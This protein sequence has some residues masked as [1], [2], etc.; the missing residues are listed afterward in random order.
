MSTGEDLKV[1]MPPP[2]PAPIP[3]SSSSADTSVGGGAA[4][5]SQPGAVPRRIEDASG[6]LL[7]MQPSSLTSR[8]TDMAFIEKVLGPDR[9]RNMR[10]KG[11]SIYWEWRAGTCGRYTG[12]FFWD[13]E[14]KQGL[15]L[16]PGSGTSLTSP[17]DH[18]WAVITV[19]N[20]YIVPHMISQGFA[21]SEARDPVAIPV[22]DCWSPRDAVGSEIGD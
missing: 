15:Q 20:E 22:A 10:A 3:T 8:R 21:H 12:K 4:S 2:K 19:Y 6:Q 7:A 11:F 9:F 5:S 1:P 16:I 17:A 18:A 14:S 13:P